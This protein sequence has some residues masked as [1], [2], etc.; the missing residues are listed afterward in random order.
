[1]RKSI[2]VLFVITAIGI[3]AYWA[4]FFLAGTVK[5]RQDEIYLC[6]QS[7]F[8]LADGWLAFC[9]LMTALSHFRRNEH[10]RIFFGVLSV[11]SMIFLA[12]IDTLFNFNQEIYRN[13]SPSVLTEIC[14]NIWLICLGIVAGRHFYKDLTLK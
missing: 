8:P 10:K 2:A 12:M 11:S 3:L 6:F 9:L 7:A 13:L 4:D 5:A 14:I 1:V